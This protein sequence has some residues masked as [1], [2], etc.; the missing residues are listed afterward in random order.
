[1]SHLHR[2][3]TGLR[4]LSTSPFN[5]ETVLER[6]VGLV[7]PVGGHY[8][9]N[10]FQVPAHDG[11]L[12]ITGSVA[13]PLDIFV[14]DLWPRATGIGLVT[15]ECA[16]N[17]RRF[18]APPAPGEQW[19]IG[20][21]GTAEWTGIPL[22]DLLE[23]AQPTENAVELVFTGADEGLVGAVGRE[24]PFERSLPIG[25]V[26]RAF[27][28]VGMNG[29]PLTANHGAPVRLL[30][31]GRYGMASVKWLTR[32][33]AVTTPFAGFFQ[34]ER[35]VVDG[36][37]L[38]DIAPRAVIAAPAGGSTLAHAETVIRG[39][40]WSGLGAIERVDV[41]TDGGST[42]SH[43]TLHPQ[44][45]ARAWR[46]WQ[47]PWRPHTAG[48]YA[49]FARATDTSGATQPIHQVRTHLGYGNNAARPVPVSVQ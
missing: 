45:S 42:W 48:E 14:T 44:P 41:S 19:G 9:R 4:V 29:E 5:A 46:Q 24:M 23:E 1:M 37:P 21:V 40:A 34:V 27:V 20:A 38:G 17:G 26:N 35:Y 28:V 31:P 43:A 16:G 2:D 13:R 33:T 47:L 7:T 6:E 8:V 10:H 25:D 36:L 18:L 49:L 3:L 15:L 11:R 32:I 30:V 12:R 22:A 39:Y